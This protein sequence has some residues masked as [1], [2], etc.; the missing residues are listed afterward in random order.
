MLG[1]GNLDLPPPP[2]DGTPPMPKL[3][4]MTFASRCFFL[5]LIS[6]TASHSVLAADAPPE[7][8]P[9]FAAGG[10]A[11]L[12]THCIACHGGDDP[13]AELSLVPFDSAEVIVKSRKAW[14]AV[15]R[16]I[17]NGEMPPADRPQPSPADVDAFTGLIREIFNHADRNAKP[18]PGRVTM[19]RL[20]RTEYRNTIRDLVGVDFDPTADFPSDDIG[21]GFDNIGDVLSISPVLME[22][23]LAA[24]DSIMSRAIVPNPPA[25][26]KR[27]LGS[28]YTEPASS[29]SGGLVVNGYRPMRSSGERP[30]DVGPVNTS[31]KWDSEGDYKFRTKV[32]KESEGDK[33]LRVTILVSGK[34]LADRSP[35]EQLDQLLGNVPRPAK[36]LKTFEVTA[37]EAAKAEVLEVDVPAI[38]GRERMLV[39]ID[40]VTGDQPPTT[41]W[42]EHLA[43][44]G[45][46]DTRPASQRR[47]LAVDP[48]RPATEQTA[49]VLGRF[50]RRAFRRDPLPEEV[51]RLSK[52]VADM[53]A[54]GE[55]W[56]SGMQVAM[57]AVLCSPKFL[58]RVEL[59][60]NPS[61]PTPRPLDDFQLAS[62][63]SYFIWN[64]M[65][66]DEL[67]D[68]AGRGELVAQLDQQVKRML[69]DKRAAALVDSFAMQWL[70]L[71]RIESIAPDM[72]R[73]PSFNAK[74]RDAMVRETELL[75]EAVVNEDR[76]ILDLIGADF[77]H[78]NEPLAR[79]Y[80]IV[81]TEGN[82]QGQA[83]VRPGGQAI[84]GDEFVRVSLGDSPRGGLLGQASLLTVTSN[85]T[86]TSPVKR[87]RW[88]LE[89]LL[90]APP[91]PAPPNVPELE[92]E[93]E[94]AAGGSLRERMEQH[95]KN[96]AC[97]NCHA[98]MDPIGFAL[99]NFDAIGAYRTK[100]GEHEIDASGEF[101]DG[102]KVDGPKELRSLI[103]Q[104]RDDFTRCLVEK[105]LTYAIGRGI[106]YYDRP[107]VERIVR[108]MPE[109]DYKFSQLVT[110]I[111]KSE[112]FLQRRGS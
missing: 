57:Q 47:L 45:P 111:V 2:N 14:D 62:R 108:E 19:R 82:L 22:R 11:F 54:G 40:K 74:L 5:L 84:K 53:M 23:Y 18:D 35:D 106:E 7:P 30:I 98:K 104:R 86:R 103:L 31:Y 29:E 25:V 41:L 65:P 32:Y 55:S 88:V 8:A 44:D 20:N 94:A 61:D 72:A 97:A 52:L 78:L 59:D 58:F 50:L 101:A 93:G 105:M 91:P 3:T 16:V 24:A 37:T 110:K 95:R 79:H 36:I 76:S 73:F 13:A 80:G 77:T 46:L 39:A 6:L 49:D 28:T 107:V 81:D 92:E 83:V 42:I 9:D 26:I 67:L 21:Y 109:G 56:E 12:K 96:P 102:T 70:Q 85:P 64:T 69:A 4:R 15:L 75:F 38:A 100:D 27:H 87:G 112:A 89:Q 34:E 33:P 68:V 66:D 63:L 90:G 1:I 43:L 71:R 48:T 17:D 60:S 99:E 10:I 51:E